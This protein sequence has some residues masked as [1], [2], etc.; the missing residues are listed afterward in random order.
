MNLPVKLPYP[1]SPV[2]KLVLEVIVTLLKSLR[3]YF[4]SPEGRE[5]RVAE[6]EAA[7]LEAK[8]TKTFFS[9]GEKV[10]KHGFKNAFNSSSST[11]L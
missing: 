7:F 1:D 9:Q 3:K 6:P 11:T 8:K 4:S 2:Q 10:F 5:N